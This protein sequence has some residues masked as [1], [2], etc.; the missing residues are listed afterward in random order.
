MNAVEVLAPGKVVLIG[1][2]AVLDG[3]PAV[4]AAVDR[5]VRCVATPADRVAIEAPGDDSFV[6]AALEGAPAATYRFEDW[7][8]TDLPSKPGLGGSAAAVVAAVL[9]ASA[10]GGA[11]VSPD[12]LARRA[13]AVHR[14]VQGS[15]S[16][17]DVA[18]SAHGG[19]IR[20]QDGTAR[21][22]APVTPVVVWSGRS[23]KT[24]PRVEAYLRWS[25]RDAFVRRSG[26]IADAFPDDPVVALR[27]ATRLLES[28]TSA[29]RIPWWTDAL[30]MISLTAARFG[31]A[32][33]PS[34]AGGGD[35]AVALFPDPERRAAFEAALTASG[36]ARIPVTLAPAASVRTFTTPP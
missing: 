22:L 13:T 35:V 34:G 32:A 3:A 10:V 31:G 24:G 33:K 21:R 14:A 23:A 19:V 16:G 9:A 26:E 5:G 28:M 8:P 25:D 29:A 6:R 27:A 1:E 12:D 36:I 7:N 20:F 11:P 17:L 2:Y 30:R 18:A 4:V 15:G